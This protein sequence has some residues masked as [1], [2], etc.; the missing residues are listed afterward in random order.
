MV[1]AGAVTELP[2]EATARQVLTA[3]EIVM[4]HDVAAMTGPQALIPEGWRAVPIAEPV[5]SGAAVG[6]EVAAASGGI[7]VAAEG[8]VVGLLADGVL[9]A[10][11]AD[12]A[13]QV[14]HATATGDI[15]LLLAP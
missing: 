14:A 1:P 11:P 6:D 3:G 7:V 15:T 2:A 5:A 9:V 13:P 8:V 12:V 4:T 10:V